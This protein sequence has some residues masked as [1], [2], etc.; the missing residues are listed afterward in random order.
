MK[1]I[2][3]FGPIL[4]QFLKKSNGRVFWALVTFPGTPKKLQSIVVDWTSRSVEDFVGD[5]VGFV[6]GGF[7]II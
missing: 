3:P 4:S 2:R 5:I 7:V 1:F 6:V